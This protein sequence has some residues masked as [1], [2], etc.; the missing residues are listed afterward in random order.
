MRDG[1]EKVTFRYK[2]HQNHTE[3][4]P[5]PL[6]TMT[7]PVMQFMA[8]FLQHVPP[9]GF[10]KVRYFG[11]WSPANRD[12]LKRIQQRLQGEN[13]AKECA[14]AEP[15]DNDRAGRQAVRCRFCKQG[16]KP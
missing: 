4:G 15:K 16:T 2:Q 14:G 9:Q 10:H 7:L 8:R 1:V 5:S 11:L 13:K 3:K 6:K 12:L